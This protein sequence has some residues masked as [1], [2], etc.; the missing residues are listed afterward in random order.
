MCLCTANNLT[1]FRYRMS[2]QKLD[3]ILRFLCNAM[4]LGMT[5]PP[6][7]QNIPAIWESL[8]GSWSRRLD[9]RMVPA[10]SMELNIAV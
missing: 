8:S 7:M 4:I 1:G 3:V 9:A 10:G 2:Y 5:M 6:I